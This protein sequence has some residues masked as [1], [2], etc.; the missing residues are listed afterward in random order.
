MEPACPRPTWGR[1]PQTA[2][3]RR[4]MCL[5]STCTAEIFE[6][7]GNGVGGRMSESGGRERRAASGRPFRLMSMDYTIR[8]VREGGVKRIIGYPPIFTPEYWRGLY[9]ATTVVE[10]HISQMYVYISPAR[11]LEPPPH[12]HHPT[13]LLPLRQR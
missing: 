4:H 9:R 1:M 7:G 12:D 6:G 8:V 11:R 13:S 2:R 10:I 5:Q 3:I